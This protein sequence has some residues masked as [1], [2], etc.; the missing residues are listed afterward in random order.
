MVLTKE[1]LQQQ[2]LNLQM[3]G[4]QVAGAIQVIKA[5]IIELDKPEPTANVDTDQK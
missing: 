1:K 5:Q 4:A 2:L 3:Q